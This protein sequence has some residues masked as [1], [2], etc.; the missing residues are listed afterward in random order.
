MAPYF[1]KSFHEELSV[2]NQEDV[3]TPAEVRQN[4]KTMLKFATDKKMPRSLVSSLQHE[5]IVNGT[6][7]GVY[8]E[9][10]FRE[11]MQNPLY[12]MGS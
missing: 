8:E 10:V 12:N 4:I 2:E 3:Y 9:S 11:Y 5:L 6:K 1:K 7:V